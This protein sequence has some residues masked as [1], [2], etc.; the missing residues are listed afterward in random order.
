MALV[1]SAESQESPKICKYNPNPLGIIIYF[2]F[3]RYGLIGA[4]AIWKPN[5]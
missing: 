1:R 3:K 4:W 2:A 5:L